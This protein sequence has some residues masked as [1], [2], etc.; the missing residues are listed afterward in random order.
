MP[1][2]MDVL[3]LPGLPSVSGRQVRRWKL[4][5]SAVRRCGRWRC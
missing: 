1:A 5:R 3:F 4:H 2:M